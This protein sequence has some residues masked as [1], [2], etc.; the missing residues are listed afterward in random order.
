MG[1]VIGKFV[2]IPPIFSTISIV[3]SLGISMGIGIIFGVIPA[4]KAAELNPIEALR[5]E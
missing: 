1:K 4:K 5:S 2:N 3:S